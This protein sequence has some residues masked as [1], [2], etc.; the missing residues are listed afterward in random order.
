MAW[1]LRSSCPDRGYDLAHQFLGEL[2]RERASCVGA[3]AAVRIECHLP[4][5]VA[6]PL[7]QRFGTG[8]VVHLRPLSSACLARPAGHGQYAPGI[9]LYLDGEHRFGYRAGGSLLSHLR[10]KRVA[11]IDDGAEGGVYALLPAGSFLV[12]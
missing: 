9:W 2:G 1:P 11:G 5:P 4:V 7:T 6:H 8:S 3:E 12:C 10:G